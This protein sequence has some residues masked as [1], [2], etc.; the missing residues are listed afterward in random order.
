MGAVISTRYPMDLQREA[1]IEDQLRI[2][3]QPVNRE[4]WILLGSCRGA[5]SSRR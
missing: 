4:G 3:R 1:S 5:A 2:C